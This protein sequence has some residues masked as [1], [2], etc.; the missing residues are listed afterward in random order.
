MESKWKNENFIRTFVTLTE[1]IIWAIS[2]FGWGACILVL[3]YKCAIVSFN[4]SYTKLFP[5]HTLYQGELAQPLPCCL[6]D[7]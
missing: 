4:L 1:K 6:I 3:D 7:P 5:T 2:G